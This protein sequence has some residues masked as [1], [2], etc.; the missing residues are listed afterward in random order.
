ML[1]YVESQEGLKR[2]LFSEED[3]AVMDRIA[4]ISRRVETYTRCWAGV[5][6]VGGDS[7]EVLQSL[8]GVEA[9]SSNP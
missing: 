8:S 5:Y 6:C 1:C 9:L 3:A 7:A 2:R 4:R